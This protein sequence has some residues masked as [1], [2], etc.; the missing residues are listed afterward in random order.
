MRIVI[1]VLFAICATR[2]VA[3]DDTFAKYGSSVSL[4]GRFAFGI[5]PGEATK[6]VTN[7]L[8]IW[9]VNTSDTQL[10][11]PTGCMEPRVVEDETAVHVEVTIPK[12]E[13]IEGAYIPYAE[14]A[15]DIV[16]LRPGEAAQLLFTNI[17]RKNY[18]LPLRIKVHFPE[19]I[20]ARFDTISGEYSA[21]L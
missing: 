11:V 4:S 13:T 19:D 8:V 17:D 15:L 6:R 9:V 1:A 14:S 3:L 2:L 20:A 21:S 10:R 12:Q 18:F 5:V 16:V 7:S